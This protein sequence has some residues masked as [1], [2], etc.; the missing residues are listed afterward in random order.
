MKTK[1]DKFREE[2]EMGKN[3][4][5][6]VGLWGV[7]VQPISHHPLYLAEHPPNLVVSFFIK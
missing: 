6:G 3:T 5:D 4:G 7:V 2:D 1:S